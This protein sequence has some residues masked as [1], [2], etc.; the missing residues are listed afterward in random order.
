MKT[1]HEVSKLSG[2]S[3]RTLHHYDAIG[4]LKPTDI[5]PAGYRLYDDTALRR[6]QS[7]LLFR[8]LQFPLKEIKTILEHP[9]FDPQEALRQ[10]KKLLQLRREQID[11]L[12]RLA[13]DMIEK[14]VNTMD[15]SAFDKEK[16][17]QYTDEVKARWGDTA[18][19]REYEQRQANCSESANTS[20]ADG[21]MAFFARFGAIK[22]RNHASPEA[23]ILAQELQAYITAN[24]YT[25]TPEILMSLATMYTADERFQ[26]NIDAV[27]GSGTAEFASHA[28]SHYCDKLIADKE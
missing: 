11:R 25:C 3:V 23:M 7:I 24:F 1:V 18:A 26:A 21:M 28:I 12:I 19:Y 20:A 22:D 14:G 8:E 5:T 17:K 4:L 6:L 2:V 13:D 16:V 27:G 9:E 10:Q 15:F